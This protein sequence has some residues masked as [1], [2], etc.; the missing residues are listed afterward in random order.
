MK[1]LLPTMALLLVACNSTVTF[2]R[3]IGEAHTEKCL[4]SIQKVWNVKPW[5]TAT[6]STSND[7]QLHEHSKP[8][9]EIC[10]PYS[11]PLWGDRQTVSEREFHMMILREELPKEIR[12]VP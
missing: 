3:K 5:R 2:E 10:E 8:E 9:G 7:V 6:G 4:S 12:I 11:I 1:I